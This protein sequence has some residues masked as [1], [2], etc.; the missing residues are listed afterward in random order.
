LEGEQKNKGAIKYYLL[1]L[2][3]NKENEGL[4][5]RTHEHLGELYF[6][7]KK[8]PL[9]YS[10]YDSTLVY[11]PKNTLEY[12]YMRRKR[13]NL[14]QITSFENTIEKADSLSRIM[15]M[16]KDEK[17][18]FFQNIWMIESKQLR[19]MKLRLPTLE[20]PYRTKHNFL[21]MV[22]TSIYLRQ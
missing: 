1:S 12:L 9:A 2:D 16:S 7:E 15:A 20:K 13:D 11:T 17:I 10:H 21:R 5:K 3:K 8:Y 19:R 6:K 4:K 22:F 14:S 18:A